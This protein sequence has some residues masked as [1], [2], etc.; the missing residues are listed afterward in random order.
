MAAPTWDP[1]AYLAFGDERT[2]PF[3]DLLSRVQ[4]EPATIVDL[5]CGPGHLM[6]V[7]R[8]R[9]PQARIVGVDSSEPMIEAARRDHSSPGIEYVHAD[10]RDWVIPDGVHL[11][12]ANATLQW[13]P[14]H[15]RLL[16]A[17]AGAVASG[18]TL[19][20]SVPG[21]FAEPSHA[22]LREMAAAEP[23]RRWTAEVEWP[24]AHDGATYL[25]LLARRGWSVE[26]W[27]TTYFHVLRG[28]DPVFAWISGT[29]ARPVLQ[30]LPRSV[31]ER[32]E[33]DY[34]ARLRAAYPDQGYGTVLPF[35]RVFVTAVRTGA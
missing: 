15:L 6:T 13:V 12:L 2:R 18:G 23:Y 20:F 26:A 17:L 34:R 25:D 7:L 19:A 30:A 29:G 31:R 8:A 21:N 16:P 32:F 4:T 24:R 10:L 3:T 28:P 14:D 22:L 9:W 27:E 1:T 11:L 5:G 35:R 33:A